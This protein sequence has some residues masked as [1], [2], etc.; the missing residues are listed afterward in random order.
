M[1]KLLA[2]LA[3]GA[4]VIS[5]SEQTTSSQ[6][7]TSAVTPSFDISNAPPQSGIVVRTG[8]S[9]ILIWGVP[10]AGLEVM[11]GADAAAFCTL[12]DGG[13]GDPSPSFVSVMT[14]ADKVLFDRVL[15][16]GQDREA[17]TQVWPDAGGGL[18]GFCAMVL[19]GAEPLA[20]GVTRGAQF[21][22]DLGGT[23]HGA[24]VNHWDYHGILTRP[25]GSQAV[26]SF[27]MHWLQGVPT[28]VTASLR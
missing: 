22:S 24:D 17:A 7:G 3:L 20:T 4:V 16:V 28:K 5:C 25:D 1:R 9:D 21:F 15:T 2:I 6:P 18:E 23:G 27:Q 26:F 19:G 14:Y 13:A 8:Y 11:M 10:S 12:W